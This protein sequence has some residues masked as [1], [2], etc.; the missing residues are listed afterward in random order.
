MRFQ[1]APHTFTLCNTFLN[2]TAWAISDGNHIKFR[3]LSDFFLI[4]LC[5]LLLEFVHGCILY[6]TDCASTESASGD[7]GTDHTRNLRRKGAL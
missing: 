2:Q 5:Q 7:T 6:D 3:C 1:S 4:C